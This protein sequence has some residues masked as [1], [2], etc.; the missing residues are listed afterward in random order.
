MVVCCTG[1]MLF[2]KKRWQNAWP[3]SQLFVALIELSAGVEVHDPISRFQNSL[4]S[5][6][7]TLCLPLLATKLV[8]LAP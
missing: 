4:I 5:S 8:C 2:C 6:T 3:W 1:S 7:T